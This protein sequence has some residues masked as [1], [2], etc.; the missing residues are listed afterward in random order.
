MEFSFNTIDELD[1]ATPEEAVA[2]GL[3]HWGCVMAGATN[4]PDD[5]G[6]FL[7]RV[8]EIS[9]VS[10]A[11]DDN[12]RKEVDKIVRRKQKLPRIINWFNLLTKKIARRIKQ[13]LIR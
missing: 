6:E 1:K 10:P 4:M 13:T 11:T 8:S 9:G 5:F 3:C 12:L 7:V 2:M